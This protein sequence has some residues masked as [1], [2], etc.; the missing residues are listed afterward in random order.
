MKYLTLSISIIA[1]ALSVYVLFK[2]GD[3]QP[4]PASL[5]VMAI[6]GTLDAEINTLNLEPQAFINAKSWDLPDTLFFA[7]E[8]VPMERAYIR[9]MFD[10][11]L[12]INTYWHNNTIFL[13]K[14]AHRWIPQMKPIF[15]EYGIPEDFLYVA[16]IESGLVNDISPSGAVGFWQFME[17][18]AEDFGLEITKDVDQRYDP[19]K[20]TRAAAKYLKKAYEKFHNWTNVAAAYN[21]GM[22]GMD[23]ALDDQLVD[24][25]YDALLNSE[26]SRY[27]FR[28]L[29]IKTIF[30]D[31][32]KY[33][34]DIKEDHLYQPEAVKQV[35]VNSDINDL[36]EWSKNQ[37]INLLL[38]KRHNPWLR[39]N[40][41]NIKGNR[42]YEI[43]IPVEK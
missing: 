24:S 17:G 11:E 5:P 25:Y 35:E 12:H 4:Q 19:I 20:S 23:N 14:R 7:G 27:L 9:E 16:V 3:Q 42:S 29:A 2:S 13:L 21:R 18:T 38:L 6:P 41:L 34:F 40:R 32:K 22:T 36:T 30:S 33:G 15:E 8:R 39:T 31:P 37:G 10:R 1:L 28:V 43:A 26:T